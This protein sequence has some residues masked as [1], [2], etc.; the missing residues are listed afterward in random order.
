MLRYDE[1]KNEAQRA[2]EVGSLKTEQLLHCQLAL[3]RLG[4]KLTNFLLSPRV[5]GFENL[6]EAVE[7][8]KKNG[9]GLLMIANHRNALDPVFILSRIPRHVQENIFPVTFLGKPQLF[10]SRF[11]RAIMDNVGCVP[12]RPCP[13]FEDHKREI[14]ERVI[15]R[16]DDGGTV[17]FFP[18][19]RVMQNGEF[20]KDFKLVEHLRH[21]ASFNLLPI[22]TTGLTS[23]KTDWFQLLTLQR[24]LQLDFGQPI[25]V[26][27]GREKLDGV[28]L[29][30]DVS[31]HCSYAL[32]YES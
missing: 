31:R 3:V 2:K 8:K 17:F 15:K 10:A 5:Q 12:I 6:Y 4:K 7:M 30:K 14:F 28:E 23:W 24:T 19:G 32:R 1:N 25:F 20:G 22:K 18:E 11:G 9:K 27:K 29:I 26:E 16:L 13:G 21:H